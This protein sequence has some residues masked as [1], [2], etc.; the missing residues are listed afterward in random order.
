[1]VPFILRFA[2]LLLTAILSSKEQH[3]EEKGVSH[4]FINSSGKLL[5]LFQLLSVL[6]MVYYRIKCTTSYF[7]CSCNKAMHDTTNNRSEI[8]PSWVLIGWTMMRCSPNKTTA[9]VTKVGQMCS[10]FQGYVC[11]HF[12]L[13]HLESLF[14]A[15]HYWMEIDWWNVYKKSLGSVEKAME[16]F[17]AKIHL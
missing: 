1:M 2:F 5:P 12:F 11:L 9:S 4:A 8:K 15:C 7:Q 16:H 14:V 6:I 13:S 3:N 17:F 10:S